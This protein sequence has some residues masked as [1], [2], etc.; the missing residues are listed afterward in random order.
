MKFPILVFTY[1]TSNPN[2]SLPFG[3]AL[4]ISKFP[5]ENVSYLFLAFESPHTHTKLSSRC[6]ESILVDVKFVRA[7]FQSIAFVL[8][9]LLGFVTGFYLKE[10]WWLGVNG[11]VTM[12]GRWFM[13]TAFSLVDVRPIVDLR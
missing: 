10:W 12:C 7:V 4:I 8:G 11:A 2:R 3:H 5:K 9:E 6:H 13:L 1:V